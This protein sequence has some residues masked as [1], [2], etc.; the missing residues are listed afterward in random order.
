MQ[1]MTTSLRP[2][3]A[4]AVALSIVGFLYFASLATAQTITGEITGTV[5]DQSDAVVPGAAVELVREGTSASRVG[6]GTCSAPSP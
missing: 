2:P 4:R 5:V 6:S 1:A 3:G